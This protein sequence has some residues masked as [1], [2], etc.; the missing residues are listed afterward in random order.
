M[1]SDGIGGG[2]FS[3]I[4]FYNQVVTNKTFDDGGREGQKRLKIIWH[5]I[6][7]TPKDSMSLMEISFKNQ[8]F[9]LVYTF[10][11]ELAELLPSLQI[12]LVGKFVSNNQCRQA[13]GGG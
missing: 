6:W 1:T 7:T 2:G 13:M 3:Q 9:K 11:K 10:S 8:Q 4:W 12:V 5:H